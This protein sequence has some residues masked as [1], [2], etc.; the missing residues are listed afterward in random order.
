MSDFNITDGFKFRMLVTTCR[1]FWLYSV[2]NTVGRFIIV[3]HDNYIKLKFV[4][5]FKNIHSVYKLSTL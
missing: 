2:V 3:N 1:Y 5:K 4:M